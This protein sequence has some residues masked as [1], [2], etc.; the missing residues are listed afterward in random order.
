MGVFLLNND[1]S[2]Y[3]IF[4]YLSYFLYFAFNLFLPFVISVEKFAVW[5]LFILVV[6]YC[7]QMNFGVPSSFYV[8]LLLSKGEE[9]TQGV[10]NQFFL[11]SVLVVFVYIFLFSFSYFIAFDYYLKFKLTNVLVFSSIVLVCVFSYLNQIFLSYYRFVKNYLFMGIV[12]NSIPFSLPVLLLFIYLGGF[13]VNVY[14][15]IYFYLIV[16]LFTFLLISISYFKHRGFFLEK[17]VSFLL[18]KRIIRQ[19]LY[20]FVIQVVPILYRYIVS[21]YFSLNIMGIY[22]FAFSVANALYLIFDVFLYL[23]YTN[24][25]T[26]IC[27]FNSYKKKICYINSKQ[28]NMSFTVYFVMTVVCIASYYFFSCFRDYSSSRDV[29]ILTLLGLYYFIYLYYKLILLISINK[30]TVVVLI[31]SIVNLCAFLIVLFSRVNNDFESVALMFVLS[32]FL[33]SFLVNVYLFFVANRILFKAFFYD[34]FLYIPSFFAVIVYFKIDFYYIL[35]FNLIILV[36]NIKEI[37]NLFCN[38]KKPLKLFV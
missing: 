11:I 31:F 27:A 37:I 4:R 17:K 2:R 15:F 29:F 23:I 24:V 32:M 1:Q 22:S 33:S 14:L 36:L 3:L 7:N 26:N 16:V 30:E 9:E 38:Y 34:L 20:N 5:A 19:F 8:S 12:Q 35:I 21:V 6:Q 18:V 10:I 13:D 25:M 28:K